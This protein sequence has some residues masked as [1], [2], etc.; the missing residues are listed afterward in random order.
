MESALIGLSRE[1]P[2]LIINH[3]ISYN[4][5]LCNT[6]SV[7]T[8]CLDSLLFRIELWFE[9]ELLVLSSVQV[10]YFEIWILWKAINKI[11]KIIAA[12]DGDDINIWSIYSNDFFHFLAFWMYV[13]LSLLNCLAHFLAG[14]WLSFS[15]ELDLLTVIFEVNKF[16]GWK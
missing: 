1:D 12:I 16:L 4:F 3:K 15:R 8:Y 7:I 2:Q 9:F 10:C 13:C 11:M 5:M 6:I 14:K